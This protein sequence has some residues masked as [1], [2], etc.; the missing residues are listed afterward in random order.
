[1]VHE[2]YSAASIMARLAGGRHAVVIH[3]SCVGEQEPSRHGHGV[4]ETAPTQQFCIICS[5]SCMHSGTL[6]LHSTLL[7]N[8]LEVDVEC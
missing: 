4:L 8:H 2:G 7:Q 5:S 3:V 1:M 6:Q